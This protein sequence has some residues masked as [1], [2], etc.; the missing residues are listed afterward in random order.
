MWNFNLVSVPM[1]VAALVCFLIAGKAWASRKSPGAIPIVFLMLS[2][3][4]WLIVYGIWLMCMDRDLKLLIAKIEYAGVVA[5]PVGWLILAFDYTE[6]RRWL[7]KRRL[8]P[9]L[10]VPVITLALVWTNDFHRLIWD[11]WTFYTHGGLLLTNLRYGIGFWIYTAFSYTFLLVGSIIIFR[12]VLTSPVIYR[13]QAGMLISAMIL[14]WIGNVIYVFKLGLFQG[15]DL[16][17]LAFTGSGILLAVGIFRLRLLDI[18][19]IARRQLIESMRDVIMIVDDKGYIIEMNPAALDMLRSKQRAIIGKSVEDVFSDRPELLDIL[20]TEGEFEQ[21]VPLVLGDEQYWFDVRIFPLR[22]KPGR[23][24]GRIITLKDITRRIKSEEKLKMLHEQFKEVNRKLTLAYSETKAQKDSL[25]SLMQRENAVFLL[26]N[27]GDILGV[28][29]QA[30]NL[31]DRTRMELINANIYDFLEARSR[32][33]M[34][35]SIR[36]A[37]VE[38]TY[39]LLVDFNVLGLGSRKFEVKLTALNMEK[40]KRILAVFYNYYEEPAAI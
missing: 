3:A 26:T 21:E 33:R 7:R 35:Q 28:T 39:K 19:P 34:K 4:E 12:F 25:N 10:A 30:I 2:I 20:R 9:I 8:I 29:N 6:Q 37:Q 38:S 23:I 27:Q 22:S 40:E 31:T 17:P 16:T 24:S 13:W 32:V 36:H 18:V 5:V 11:S 14:P 15:I 1:F